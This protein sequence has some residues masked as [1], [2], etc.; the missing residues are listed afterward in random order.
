M[1]VFGRFLIL[2]GGFTLTISLLTACS[3]SETSPSPI[4][5]TATAAATAAATETATE[6]ATATATA[7]PTETATAAPTK[8]A[9]PMHEVVDV[10]GRTVMIPVEPKVIVALSPTAVEFVYAAG[11]TVAGRPSTATH[12][13]EA[14]TAA[15]VGTAYS[16][17][18]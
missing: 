17:S 5:E 3:D 13:E 10:T 14:L 18:Q 4:T 2:F 8:V 12:P 16:P 6:T 7:A 1:R 11:G 9:V 15:E